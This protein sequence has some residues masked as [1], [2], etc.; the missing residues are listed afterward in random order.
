MTWEREYFRLAAHVLLCKRLA[1]LEHEDRIGVLM[2][3]MDYS[4]EMGRVLQEARRDFGTADCNN[5]ST[6]PLSST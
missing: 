2:G 1:V 6:H 3:E 5:S 4:A